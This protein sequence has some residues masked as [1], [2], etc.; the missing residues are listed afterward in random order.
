MNDVGIWLIVLGI[1]VAL[2]VHS[3][4]GLL[5]VLVGAA[6]LIARSLRT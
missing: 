6:L 2:L 5:M 3:G 4:V 1:G